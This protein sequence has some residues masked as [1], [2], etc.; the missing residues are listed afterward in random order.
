MPERCRNI[1]RGLNTVTL[2]WEDPLKAN[3]ILKS[4]KVRH[5]KRLTLHEL[6]LFVKTRKLLTGNLS[7]TSTGSSLGRYTGTFPELI[8]SRWF[9]RQSFLQWFLNI[10]EYFWIFLPIE[11][12][13]TEPPVSHFP[14]IST[15][16]FMGGSII[17]S[18]TVSYISGCFQ[19][20]CTPMMI[21]NNLDS[22]IEVPASAHSVTLTTLHPGTQYV[23]SIKASTRKGFGHSCRISFWTKPTG[24]R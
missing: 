4:Y 18:K 19:V 5:R 24:T 2:T 8:L 22:E 21:A 10:S 14:R 7:V 20:L 17:F 3:G 13:R 23:C 11:R 16:P 15:W 9:P 12:C 6:V 1:S